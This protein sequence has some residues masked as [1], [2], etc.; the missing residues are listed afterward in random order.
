MR[1]TEIVEGRL[2]HELRPGEGEA[3]RDIGAVEGDQRRRVAMNVEN[4]RNHVAQE[5]Q[6]EG[7]EQRVDAGK[8]D[9]IMQALAIWPTALER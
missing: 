5:K 1:P 4:D 6:R 9:R 2:G 8:K 3:H 7:G